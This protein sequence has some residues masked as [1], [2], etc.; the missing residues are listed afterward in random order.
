M[1]K[2][3]LIEKLPGDLQPWGKIWIPA[4]LRWSE[5]ELADFLASVAGMPWLEAYK[6]MIKTMT[7]DELTAELKMRRVELERLNQD[8]AAFI[9]AQRT[10]FFSVLA[11]LI[12]SLGQ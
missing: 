1:T 3:E 5:K 7:T 2:D 11:K 9:D 12:L 10:L 6:V 4:M 8:N